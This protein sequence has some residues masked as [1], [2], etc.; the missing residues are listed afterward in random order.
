MTQEQQALH[1]LHYEFVTWCNENA[2]PEEGDAEDLLHH[3][4]TTP[5]QRAYLSAFVA[6][7]DEATAK[8]SEH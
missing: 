6:R 4:N 3:P 2:M 7:W 5:E 1:D 8:A